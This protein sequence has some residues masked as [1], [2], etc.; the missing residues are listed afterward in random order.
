MLS[1]SVLYM[2]QD[3]EDAEGCVCVGWGGYPDVLELS[4]LPF[5]FLYPGS[6]LCFRLNSQAVV[7]GSI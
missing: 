5:Q 2:E 4:R 1:L 6:K 3:Q 7:S